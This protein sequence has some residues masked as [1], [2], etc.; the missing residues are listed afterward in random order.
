MLFTPSI[1]AATCP[2]FGICGG[3]S[4]EAQAGGGFAPPPYQE[5]L[6][7]KEERV[8]SLLAPF[9]VGE[10][11]PIVP[12]PQEWYYRNKMEYAFAVPFTE[13]ALVLG[14][15]EAG[16]Y[17][18]V[19]DLEECLLMSPESAELLRRIR[20][21]ALARGLAGYH[22]R[23]HR[24][25]LRYLVVREGKNTAQRMLILIAHPSVPMD[26]TLWREFRDAAEPLATTAWLGITDALGDVARA[27]DMRLLWG[28]GFIDEKLGDLFFR[29]SPYSFFQTNTKA[30][31]TLY[32]LLKDWAASFRA[33]SGALLDLYCGAGGIGLS[34][35]QNFDRVVGVDSNREAI[36]NAIFNAER[37]ALTN[38]EFVAGDALDFLKKLPASKLAVQLSAVVVDPPRAGLV[39]R[40]LQTLIE[41]N[42]QRL[43]YVSCNPES[44][45]RDLQSLVPLYAIQSVQPVDLFP[46][47]AHVETV[48][49]L[50]HR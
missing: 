26:E 49:L 30:T 12:A 5:E 21:W 27:V 23:A 25:Q 6:R 15:R 3:C 13:G 20:R 28:D 39:P 41:L 7:R 43:A 14:L 47:T 48:A 46:H 10:W 31:E 19:I 42:P 17:D 37:N 36:E 50:E 16:R 29:I 24:G 44:L 1:S 8:R 32:G 22:R 18:R 4:T 9:T 40:A 45:A 35:A 11:R 38:T 33:P 2:H 34:L